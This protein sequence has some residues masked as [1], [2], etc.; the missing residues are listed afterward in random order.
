[1]GTQAQILD[2]S[3]AD[4]SDPKLTRL[5]KNFGMLAAQILAAQKGLK[6]TTAAMTAVTTP[7][8][9]SGAGPTPTPPSPSNFSTI[10]EASQFCGG[11]GLSD[12]CINAAIQSA[13]TA[14]AAI[15]CKAGAWQINGAI[16]MNKP[17]I[18]LFGDGPGTIFQV[19]AASTFASG[20]VQVTAN[21]NSIQSLLL[22]GSITSST[23]LDFSVLFGTMAGDPMHPTLT[24]NSMIWVSNG[25]S[26]FYLY[27]VIVQDCGGYALLLD[28]RM[29]NLVG[30]NVLSCIFQ[31]NIA[32][33]YG[34]TTGG[35][36]YH[37]VGSWV[38]GI[39]AAGGGDGTNPYG[40]NSQ[41]YAA[42]QVQGL[43][44][45][46]CTFKN[47][48]GNCVWSYTYTTANLHQ[49]F[50]V[51]GS[52]FSDVGRD[53]TEMG[54]V[55]NFTVNNNYYY[56]IGYVAGSPAYYPGQN[57]VAIDT[58][59]YCQNGKYSGNAMLN[60]NGECIDLDGFTSGEVSNNSMMI[61][62]N[63][64]PLYVTD[65]IANY[66]YSPGAAQNITTGIQTNATYDPRGGQRVTIIGNTVQNMGNMAVNLFNAQNDLV[67]GN[68]IWH[69][70]NSSLGATA[71][72]VPVL[73]G[74][75]ASTGSPYV[76]PPRH[77]KLNVITG[78]TINYDCAGVQYCVAEVDTYGTVDGPNYV[79][80]NRIL[81]SNLGEFLPSS[82]GLAG[83]SN[84]SYLFHTNSGLSSTPQA[85]LARN[86]VQREG[87]STQ[88]AW[89]VYSQ[90]LATNVA[91]L[92]M[93]LGDTGILNVSQNGAA[94]TGALVTASRS[95]FGS[96][97][98]YLYVG[99]TI[100]DG[101]SVYG[102][103]NASTSFYD[104]EANSLNDS[105]GLIRYRRT[106]GVGS[107]GVF[108]ISYST[109]GG[110]RVWNTIGA[111]GGGSPG[112]GDESIQYNN[113]SAFGGDGN[114]LW[115][116][117]NQVMSIRGK[118]GASSYAA[119]VVTDLN[120]PHTAYA[121]FDG[122][123]LSNFNSWQSI[124]GGAQG[125]GAYL[126]GHAI[127]PYSSTGGYIDFEV[128]GYAN[129]PAP[130]NG[131]GSFGANDVLL[132]ASATNS[133]VT[134]NST[135][136]LQT[137][138]FIM[139]AGGFAV[140][141][142]ASAPYN[143]TDVIQAKAGGVTARWLIASD[144]L[145]LVA[146][147]APAL[148][149][150]GQSRFYMDSTSHSVKVSMDGAA[151]RDLFGASSVAG[152]DT[153][154]QYNSSSSFGADGNL[155]WDYTGQALTV[156]G[157]TG[158]AAYAALLVTDSNSPHT[159]YIQSDGGFLTNNTN[160][161]AIQAPSGGVTA[162]LLIATDSWF[163][164]QEAAP[165]LS[166]SGQT[167]LYM[168]STS[169]KV[170]ISQNGA[171]Y[172]DLLGSVAVAG[173]DQQIQY[174]HAGAF[175]ADA[176]FYWD[177]TNK[178]FHVK[179]A[180]ASAAVIESSAVAVLD[181]VSNA[182]VANTYA[183]FRGFS[184][185]G[186][187]FNIGTLLDGYSYRGSAI[188]PSSTVAGDSLMSFRG[189]GWAGSA[190]AFGG[191]FALIAG[192]NWTSIS[193]ET[194]LSFYTTAAGSTSV[195]EHVRITGLGHV[196][197]NATV[198]DS[199][200][201]V[202]QMTGFVSATVGY[203]S[204]GSAFDTFKALAGGA[205]LGLGVTVD[206]ALYSKTLSS[207]PNP[208]GAGYAAF[209]HNSGS[210]WWY[211]NPSTSAWSTVNL[212]ALSGGVTSL[213]G[214]TGAVSIAA[215][216]GITVAAGGAS[217]TVTNAGVTSLAGTTNQVTVSAA[218]GGVTISLP[219]NVVLGSGSSG[220]IY[221]FST[222]FNAIST[223]GGL[224]V[225]ENSAGSGGSGANVNDL[226]S[227]GTVVIDNNHRFVG[228]GV[229]CPSYGVTAA[230]FN[231]FVGG[232]QY[233]GALGPYMLNWATGFTIGAVTYHNIEI[234]GGCVVGIS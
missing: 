149:A 99:K 34:G 91:T 148:S 188:S 55:Q 90:N 88:G 17:N 75:S 12:V 118:T 76:S 95:T 92:L 204:A 8:V 37:G 29:Q 232:I 25:A 6:T 1:M 113:S 173:S 183:N 155:T 69:P 38:G 81:G 30:M 124:N 147:S 16:L 226:T 57:A 111:G 194:Y 33:V 229:Y 179:G 15:H 175:G 42:T 195:L 86:I 181:V 159:A 24:N 136:G 220:A 198:D 106:G 207:S 122:G 206:Q 171:A 222:A 209:A 133:T 100:V 211:Y 52:L 158:V 151:Y 205:H 44:V 128:L 217:V 73:L 32:L 231:P 192:S 191:Q 45:S 203:Y 182:G 163:L 138:A 196:L 230:D 41:V 225:R 153:M 177:Y 72:G 58:S 56:R 141:N 189:F 212:A 78:N 66:G 216:T 82:G 26:T 79:Y 208:P 186:S 23:E 62:W 184:Y 178:T 63:T 4:L 165:A 160:Q 43:V 14:G 168:D 176:N 13:P 93:Q 180:S 85:N 150:S 134:P 202:L 223:A 119:F 71:I 218:T 54:D 221:C 53:G 123:L 50:S 200:G 2:I 112:G 70:G 157:K 107:G 87:V 210:T 234:A 127:V 110:L 142:T 39:F 101:Y 166:A 18:L 169:H 36:T 224:A 74:T 187:G 156:K 7:S 130:L 83:G 174:N 11:G 77:N 161:N 129:F 98:D 5:N 137:N 19:N 172:V 35:H 48:T 105:Y 233:T 97:V 214:L 121:R 146:E 162:A 201:A 164:V 126:A 109:S 228:E 80:N 219:T 143:N 190:K 120:T 117:T 59:G 94:N 170:R 193:A 215:G 125:A 140:P 145:F 68:S 27:N 40:Y 115:D 10:I 28:S 20:V 22:E 116:Y 64:D 135:Y 102:M 21:N 47:I 213:N 84:S 199:S 60:V 227:N 185:S 197:I 139:A 152:S 9:S 96:L 51:F 108:E 65:Q 104:T 89:K 61:S 3:P 132:W 31:N 49:N 167:R 144:S 67:T 114:L 154:L 103:Y 131:L 46:N